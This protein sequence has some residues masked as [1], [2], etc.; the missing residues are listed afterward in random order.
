MAVTLDNDR[1]AIPLANLHEEIQRA[2]Q[3]EMAQKIPGHSKTYGGWADGSVRGVLWNVFS[4]KVQ[5]DQRLDE[6]F[7]VGDG[8]RADDG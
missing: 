7:A 5:S 1:L 8:S 2:G 3:A 6:D 4:R